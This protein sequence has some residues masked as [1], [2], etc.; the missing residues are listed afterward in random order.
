MLRDFYRDGRKYK[1]GLQ[2]SL[3]LLPDADRAEIWDD[4][5]RRPHIH[6]Q[7]H[8]RGGDQVFLEKHFLKRAQRWQ[9]VLPGQIV[10]AK[11]DCGA[12]NAFRA[13]VVPTNARVIVFHG[14]PRPWD[15][16]EFEELYAV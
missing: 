9:D 1:E 4:W 13:V 3:M 12:G 8:V 7:E 10:S 2:S 6:M 16:P 5:I 14:K 15:C 11:V